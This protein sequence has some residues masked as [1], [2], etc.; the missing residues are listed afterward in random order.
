MT[1]D[2][3]FCSRSKGCPNGNCERN[4][5]NVPKECLKWIWVSDFWEC[6]NFKNRVKNRKYDSNRQNARMCSL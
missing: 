3:T 4:L 6:D 2:I 1:T 5:T